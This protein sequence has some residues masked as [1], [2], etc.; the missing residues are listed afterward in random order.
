MAISSAASASQRADPELAA[1]CG[2]AA[3]V[4]VA[5]R[6]QPDVVAHQLR[7]QHL[8]GVQAAADPADLQGHRLNSVSE[9]WERMK[10]ALAARRASSSSCGGRHWAS[11]TP[12]RSSLRRNGSSEIGPA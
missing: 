8:G 10:A 12:K 6:G 9:R 1:G 11:G 2:E 3:G 4:D 5:E 7:Q